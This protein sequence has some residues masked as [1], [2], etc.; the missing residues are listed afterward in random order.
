MSPTC[1]F[2]CC[3]TLKEKYT[4]RRVVT[5]LHSMGLKTEKC[6]WTTIPSSPSIQFA[7]FN[8]EY[9]DHFGPI[10]SSSYPYSVLVCFGGINSKP[11]LD[12]NF[13]L[14]RKIIISC[15]LMLIVESFKNIVVFNNVWHAKYCWVIIDWHWNVICGV[16]LLN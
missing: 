11:I 13:L 16:I 7:L 2:W 10:N 1:L 14:V 12:F 3:F 9:T 5:C 6:Y 8:T 4:K 15:N